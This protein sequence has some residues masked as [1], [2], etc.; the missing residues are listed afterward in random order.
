[1]KLDKSILDQLDLSEDSEDEFEDDD[2]FNEIID[3]ETGTKVPIN[4]IIGTQIIKNYL[5][6]LK[7]GPES[8]NIIS[9]K[10]LYKKKKNLKN[11][12]ESS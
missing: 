7:N 2:E 4:S 8:E 5:E 6:C 3:P 11:N 1:M 10:M 12:S 9:T